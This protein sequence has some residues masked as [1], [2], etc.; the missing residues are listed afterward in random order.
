MLN[1]SQPPT[2]RPFPVANSASSAATRNMYHN[3][4]S[5]EL[6]LLPPGPL[7]THSLIL[8]A[9]LVCQYIQ[10]VVY[11]EIKARLLYFNSSI[12]YTVPSSIE[13]GNS[14]GR[15]RKHKR[16]SFLLLLPL[17]R[18][19]RLPPLLTAQ[20]TSCCILLLLTG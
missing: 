14:G 12:P 17:L 18:L 2:W 11:N 8:P 1:S 4:I 13:C 9:S 16:C 6:L 15:K 19:S 10:R 20:F 5:H 3:F 7:P